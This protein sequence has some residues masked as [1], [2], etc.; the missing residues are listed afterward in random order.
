L[1]SS[2][3]VQKRDAVGTGKSLPKVIS[4]AYGAGTSKR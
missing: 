3:S 1:S 2:D 4:I